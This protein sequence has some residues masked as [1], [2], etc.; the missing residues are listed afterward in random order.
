MICV[1]GIGDLPQLASR[2]E[3]FTNKF[4]LDYHQLALDCME[5]LV[6]NRTRDEVLGRRRFDTSFYQKLDF[7]Q[8]HL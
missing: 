5:E 2:P 6:L 1:H 4:Y 8:N 7:V 3:L